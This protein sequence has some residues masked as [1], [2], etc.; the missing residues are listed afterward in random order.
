MVASKIV[1]LTTLTVP[2]FK[3]TSKT[4]DNN[5]NL[6]NCIKFQT[7]AENT[8]ALSYIALLLYH[9]LQPNEAILNMSDTNILQTGSTYCGSKCKN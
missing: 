1:P 8:N 7:N 9:S 3:Q 6:Y 2:V 5:N 4:V